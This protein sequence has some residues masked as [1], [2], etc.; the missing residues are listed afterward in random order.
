MEQKGTEI[1]EMQAIKYLI[2]FFGI[3]E[4]GPKMAFEEEPLTIDNSYKEDFVFDEY[5]VIIGTYQEF[6][7]YPDNCIKLRILINW[8]E[9]MDLKDANI[10]KKTFGIALPNI[11]HLKEAEK[12][13]QQLPQFEG[14]EIYPTTEQ[15]NEVEEIRE[16]S[17]VRRFKERVFPYGSWE[18][19]SALIFEE[20]REVE[21]EQ[22]FEQVET[23]E[24]DWTSITKFKNGEMQIRTSD[25]I[26]NLDIYEIGGLKFT[27]P[28][29][30][31]FL[32]T[33][34]NYIFL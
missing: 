5:A 11:D 25:G 10:I 32:Y 3:L 26:R 19:T 33:E 17:K 21:L 34:R 16:L 28:D 31:R 6:Q 4:N 14:K 22:F 24:S 20:V 2:A 23:I 1:S 18:V 15:L 9:W 13:L 7:K 29:E 12:L 30:I 27:D 8:L